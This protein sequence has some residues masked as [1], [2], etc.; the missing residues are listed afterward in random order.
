MKQYEMIDAKLSFACVSCGEK[1]ETSVEIV[2]RS[3]NAIAHS[4][5][6][7]CNECGTL[8]EIRFDIQYK[9]PIL[10]TLDK[11]EN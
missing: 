6:V 3:I 2:G 11:G 1:Q 9:V 8:V 4:R 7:K 10:C 5:L